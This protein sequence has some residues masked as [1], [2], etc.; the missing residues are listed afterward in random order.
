MFTLT[1]HKYTPIMGYMQDK[2]LKNAPCNELELQTLMNEKKAIERV[3]RFIR[4]HKILENEEIPNT[5]KAYHR[6]LTDIEAMI[7]EIE[8]SGKTKQNTP[9]NRLNPRGLEPG[10]WRKCTPTQ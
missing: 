1:V 3:M 7:S 10:G 9:Q 8:K 4:L 6:A 2:M 5:L